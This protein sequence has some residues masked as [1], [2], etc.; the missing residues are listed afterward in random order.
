FAARTPV[1][2]APPANAPVR[3]QPIHVGP[4]PDFGG[5]D[6]GW[7]SGAGAGAGDAAAGAGTGAGAAARAG[8]GAGAST[9]TGT[10]AATGGAAP[11]SRTTVTSP[12]RSA[13]RSTS[14]RPSFFPVKVCEPGGRMNG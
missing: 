2:T 12:A 13:L 6:A 14:G 4:A 8:T 9:G 5:L 7:G 10:G 11:G 3:P 1:T